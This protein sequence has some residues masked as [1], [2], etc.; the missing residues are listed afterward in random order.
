MI[1][2]GMQD[3]SINLEFVSSE[4]KIGYDHAAFS[5][6]VDCRG[7]SGQNHEG[8]FFGYDLDTFLTEL[9][10]LEEKRQGESILKCVSEP[11]DYR[12]FRFKIYSIDKLGHLAITIE[13]Q[14]L[15]YI[16]HSLLPSKVTTSFEIDPSSLPEILS[17]FQILVESYRER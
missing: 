3:E 12:E 14:K 4:L 7:F 1:I 16:N 6:S 2:R 10:I 15:H 11:S 5:I 13:L 8:W 17:D 9:R